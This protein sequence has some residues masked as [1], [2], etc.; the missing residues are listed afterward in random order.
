MA[1]HKTILLCT[2]SLQSALTS[3]AMPSLRLPHLVHLL[4]LSTHHSLKL[5]LVLEPYTQ[6]RERESERGGGGEKRE[7]EEEE[8]NRKRERERERETRE[9]K[10]EKRE[11]SSIT[12]ALCTYLPRCLSRLH[13]MTTQTVH[14]LRERVTDHPSG[15]VYG[16]RQKNPASAHRSM[17]SVHYEA[18]APPPL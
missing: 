14:E 15:L 4:L 3:Q 13:G 12:R 9:R 2:H 10:G 17:A 11:Y 6:V 8:R 18:E 1:Q 16:N 7:I 5:S